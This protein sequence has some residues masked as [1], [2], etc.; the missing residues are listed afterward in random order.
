[1]VYVSYVGKKQTITARQIEAINSIST[2][3]ASGRLVCFRDLIKW[4]DRINHFVSLEGAEVAETAFHV[5]FLIE[6][7]L[8]LKSM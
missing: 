3:S 6:G 2:A 1:M 5:S 7:Y 4:C 8:N